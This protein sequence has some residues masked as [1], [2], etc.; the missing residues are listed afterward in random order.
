[1]KVVFLDI[2]GVLNNRR[3][4]EGG[5]RPPEA[6]TA[7]H[8]L[9]PD[10]VARMCRVVRFASAKVVVSSTW[11]HIGLERVAACLERAGWVAPPIIGRT[12]EMRGARGQEIAAWLDE[13]PEVTAYAIVDDNADML[14]K[15]MPYLVQ[16]VS[17]AGFT[18]ADGRKLLAF[19]LKGPAASR[20]RDR[21]ANRIC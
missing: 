10:C 21:V 6:P 5:W 3:S 11:R 19:L 17:A 7:F 4:M 2:D 15:Q 13:H 16:T 1:M 20:S 8:T 18:D 9:D 14:P 12:P